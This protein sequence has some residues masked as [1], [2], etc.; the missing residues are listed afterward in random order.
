MAFLA[1]KSCARTIHN[2]DPLFYFRN[3][4][5]LTPRAAFHI[6]PECPPEYATIINESIR[7]G[8]LKPVAFMRD[9]EQTFELLSN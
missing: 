7:K 2:E 9:T 5:I 8:W 4:V 6:L 1:Q 3:G